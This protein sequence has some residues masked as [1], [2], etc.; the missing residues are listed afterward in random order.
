MAG[1]ERDWEQVYLT[2]KPEELPWNAGGPDPDLVR[3]VG[4]G[5][6]P[7]GHAIDI[8][9]G[10][11]HDAVY[12]IEQGFDVVGIDISAAAIALARENAS[13]KGLFAFFQTADVRRLPMEDGYFDFANDRGC[14]HA[15]PAGDRPAAV[16]QVHRVLKRGGLYLLRVFSEKE[17]PRTDG[18]G[19]H[20]FSRAE[21]E[22]LF[23]A[24]FTI[25]DFWEGRFAGSQKPRSYSI[26]MQKR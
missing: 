14:F 6:I 13:A 4:D 15:L 24:Y 3:L 9:T 18:G 1:R 5:R 8:G 19:P 23:P 26:L 11:G 17:P 25:L 20:R 7:R 21:L 10:P 12:L 16:Q 22:S 2:S